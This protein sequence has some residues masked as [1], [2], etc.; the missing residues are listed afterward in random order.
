M[1]VG[2]DGSVQDQDIYRARVRNRAKLAYNSVAAW[3]E[4]GAIAGRRGCRAWAGENLQ[5]QDRVSPEDERDFGR[6]TAPSTS[7]PIEARPIF[8]GDQSAASKRRSRTVPR[9]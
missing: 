9:I 1:I 7:S 6:F 5:F 3:L 2:A 8:D 4:G